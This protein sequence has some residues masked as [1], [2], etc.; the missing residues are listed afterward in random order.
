VPTT[1]GTD[2]HA[3]PEDHRE[4]EDDA[5]NN[6]DQCRDLKEPM[7]PAPRSVPPRQRFSARCRLVLGFT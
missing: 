1:M 3:G 2:H 4:D 5:G 6:H 7:W